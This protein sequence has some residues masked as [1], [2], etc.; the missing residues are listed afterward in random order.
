MKKGVN[1]L[2][3]SEYASLYAVRRGTDLDIGSAKNQSVT[4]SILTLVKQK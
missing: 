2:I 4:N 1:T 3:I